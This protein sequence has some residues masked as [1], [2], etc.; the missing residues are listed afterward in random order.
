MCMS[1]FIIN[2]KKSIKIKLNIIYGQ[3]E[4]NLK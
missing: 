2:K 4:N 1:K 3:R